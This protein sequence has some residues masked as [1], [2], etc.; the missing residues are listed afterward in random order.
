MSSDLKGPF[1]SWKVKGNK[2]DLLAVFRAGPWRLDSLTWKDGVIL[3]GKKNEGLLQCPYSFVFTL[4]KIIFSGNGRPRDETGKRV[5]KAK[6]IT[7]YDFKT[8]SPYE[9]HPLDDTVSSLLRY[10]EGSQRN[11]G[12]ARP[13]ST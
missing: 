11:N 9:L 4:M 2:N 7:W 5:L 8:S 13:V 12:D 3:T 1:K 10:S 6:L